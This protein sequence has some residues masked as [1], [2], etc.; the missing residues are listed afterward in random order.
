[1]RTIRSVEQ[2][3]GRS[4][5]G[6]KDYSAIIVVGADLVRL[7]R[8]KASR[9][10]LSSQMAT[11][12]EL[13]LEIAD[14]AKQNIEDGKT[15]EEALNGLLR[16][17]LR[18]DPDWKAFYAEQMEKVAP[19]GAN[20][21]V[22]KV[23]AAELAAEQAYAAGDYAAASETLQKLLDGKAVDADDKGWYLQER[24]RYHYLSD[25]AKS[26]KLQVAAH[27]SNRLLLRPPERRDGG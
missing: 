21:A 6:E 7:I 15:P 16:Q 11:Q 26:Q 1:M 19:S 9:R 13:G 4:V 3:M 2:G 20:A 25:R 12:I 22:L 17:C 10:F 27:K 8:E 18:R 24:A 5:R 23:Y 14:M